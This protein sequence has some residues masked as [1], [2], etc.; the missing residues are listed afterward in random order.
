MTDQQE[1]EREH[2]AEEGR[3]A[4]RGFVEGVNALTASMQALAQRHDL[5]A[6][7]NAGLAE[8]LAV[9]AQQLAGTQAAIHSL[10]SQMGELTKLVGRALNIPIVPGPPAP[11][12]QPQQDPFARMGAGLVNGVVDR[13]G[14]GARRPGGY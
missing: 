10:Q 1:R 5:M 12:P 7:Q 4:L 11:Q 3:Q 2:R 14:R 8:H 13:L 9:V 6:A